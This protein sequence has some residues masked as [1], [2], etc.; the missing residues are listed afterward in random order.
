MPPSCDVIGALEEGAAE[1]L[2]LKP[3]QCLVI[4]AED[5]FVVTSSKFWIDNIYIAI[6]Y[7]RPPKLT[8]RLDWFP[9]GIGF[10]QSA[11]EASKQIY[12][13]NVTIQGDGLGPA[14]GLGLDAT[15]GYVEGK[16]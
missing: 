3:S 13:T 11:Q 8:G 9:A 7:I 14:V 16:H 12:V 2:P 10:T 5:I 6:T 1:L 4:A 15:R